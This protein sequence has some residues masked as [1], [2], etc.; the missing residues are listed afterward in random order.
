MLKKNKTQNKGTKSWSSISSL[1]HDTETGVSC[2]GPCILFQTLRWDSEQLIHRCQAG[3]RSLDHLECASGLTTLFALFKIRRTGLL[4][5]SGFEVAMRYECVC[6]NLT[7][8]LVFFSLKTELCFL[9][10]HAC[11]RF[12]RHLNYKHIKLY[13]SKIQCNINYVMLYINDVTWPRHF[14]LFNFLVFV[15]NVKTEKLQS[16]RKMAQVKPSLLWHL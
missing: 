3:D 13:F 12:A 16:Y 5:W 6:L 15:S 8:K 4:C 10:K 11:L 14:Y 9:A 7:D 1:P 2:G